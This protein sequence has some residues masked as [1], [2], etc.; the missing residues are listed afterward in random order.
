MA[1]ELSKTRTSLN[2]SA[3]EQLKDFSILLYMGNK[4]GRRKT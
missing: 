4:L 3:L 2:L 1:E